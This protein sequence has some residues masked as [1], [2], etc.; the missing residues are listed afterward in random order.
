MAE[1]IRLHSFF[2]YI[3]VVSMSEAVSVILSDTLSGV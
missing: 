2:M 1:L 3:F